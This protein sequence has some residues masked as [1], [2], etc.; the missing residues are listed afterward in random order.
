MGQLRI[1]VIPNML[2]KLYVNNVV[3]LC[4]LIVLLPFSTLDTQSGMLH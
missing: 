3:N 2:G 4:S 1:F